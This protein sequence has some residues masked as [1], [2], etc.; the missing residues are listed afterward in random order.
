[1]SDQPTPAPPAAAP[2]SR[3]ALARTGAW[4]LGAALL[5]L[6]VAAVFGVFSVLRN[7]AGTAWLLQNVPGLQVTAPRGALLGQ[8]FGADRLNFSWA[9]GAA[10]VELEG[11]EL[12]G[13]HWRWWLRPGVW[14]G[15]QA[16]SLTARR[17]HIRSGPP[18]ETPLTAPRTLRLPVEA[19]IARVAA[20]E[21]QI[22]ELPPVRA[23]SGRVH[24]G[25]Q[26][27]ALHRIDNLA[28]EWDRLRGS[29]QARLEADAPFALDAA[30]ALQSTAGTPWTAS[31]S[32]LGPL[33]AFE[34]RTTLRGE[35]KAG[36]APPALEAQVQLLP[37]AAWPVGTLNARTQALDLSALSSQAPQTRLSGRAVVTS[38]G[39]AAP[40]GAQIDFDN[41]LPGRWNEGR[42][43]VR[44][45]QLGLLADPARRDRVE[46]DTFDIQF[47]DVSAAAGRWSGSGT[48][49]GSMFTLETRMAALRPQLLDA[50]APAMTLTGPLSLKIDGL[51]SPAGTAQA[52]DVARALQVAFKG[53]LEGSI[54]GAPQPVSL[55]VEGDANTHRVE[56]HKLHA[57]SGAASAEMNASAER[58]PGPRWQV[59]SEGKL[60]DFDP[61]P[62]FPGAQGSAWR[63]GPHRLNAGWKLDL[64]LAES[65]LREPVLQWLQ[66]LQGEGSLQL[67]NSQLAGVPV[68]AQ[69]QLGQDPGAAK[70]QRS[71]AQGEVLLGSNRITIDG[72]G[73]PA[74][75]GET[76]RVRI[77]VSAGALAELAPLAALDPAL[78][79]WAPRGGS[80]EATVSADGRWPLLHTEADASLK[81]V[82]LGELNVARGSAG[83]NLDLGRQQSLSV[84][85]ELNDITL[86]TRRVTV[87]RGEL[88]GTLGSH[89][90]QLDM[91]AP[92]NP[93]GVL[94][95]V[96][97]IKAQAGT[98][99]QLAAEGSWQAAPGGGG[100]WSGTLQ[101]LTAGV[102][103]GKTDKRASNDASW[104]DVDAVRA[105]VDVDARGEVSAANATAGT[106]KLAG[107]G[108]LRWNE[109]R[110]R[111]A[112]Q[113]PDLTLQAE[114]LPI[115]VAP[116]LQRAQTGIQWGGDLRMS[117]A[118]D[119]RAGE[120][121]DADVRL[122][123]HDGDLQVIEN[124]Q[125]QPLGLTDAD[126]SFTAHDGVWLVK[127]LFAGSTLGTI[128]GA[129]TVRTSP[130][131][132]WPEAAAPIDGA[133]QAQVP[134]L[135]VWARWVPPGWRIEGEASTV[136]RVTGRFGAPEY[137]GELRGTGIG[138]RNL[139]QGLEFSDG[140]VLISLKGDRA[141]IERL[142]IRGG[143]G[144]LT[145]QGGATFGTAP[146]AQLKVTA[147][148]FRV[149]GRIDRQLVASGNAT[150]ALQPDRLRLEGRV[151]IDSGLFDLTR[152][153]APSLDD[154]VTVRREQADDKQRAEA[155]T[156]SPI[157]RTAVV[158]IDIGLGDKLFL[159]GR[160]IDTRLAGDLKVST[161][162]GRLAVNGSVRAVD[163]TYNAYGQNLEI[164]R[165]LVVFSGPVADPQLNI[166][167]LRQNLDVRVGVAIAGSATNPRVRLYSDPEMSE[168]DKLSW[169][170]LG[171][172]PDGLGRTDTALVQGAALALLAGEG[173][174]PT[175]KVLK[176][177]GIDDLSF[178]QT[179]G[180]TRDTVIMLGKQLNRQW[181]VGYE[182]GVN[183]ASGS[184]QVIY[185]IAQRFTLRAQSGE[186]N[187]LDLI[188]TWRLGED[189]LGLKSPK[190]TKKPDSPP[191]K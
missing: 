36:Q 169:L 83:W 174:G 96:L 6:P 25:A 33:T 75:S 3:F 186:D 64:A 111:A 164:E 27:G 5:V 43:P 24:A 65:A 63:K 16:D 50:R 1:M 168:T 40:I 84:R 87:L 148:R 150:L 157:A 109:I 8:N 138:V 112:G 95:R 137:T 22:D 135:S 70:A 106:A 79:P 103:D 139:L 118:I 90:L 132:R 128:S 28:F 165:G 155:A 180:D 4:A 134:N 20:D 66:T 78:A 10:G 76:D 51:P 102:W 80:L 129:V 88:S 110:Y 59:R 124:G 101:R 125:V 189:P 167:A 104:V 34:L 188:W 13:A 54:D 94:E 170:I 187:S 2:K 71:R 114:L 130:Q 140:D 74:G 190:N 145:A 173:E 119:I 156:V 73:D 17:V 177:I 21:L 117:A 131:R 171:R 172:G 39:M 100:T 142:S 116:M 175:D 48:W 41:T 35:A 161:P 92:I 52:G 47:G 152:S 162:G 68:Q 91:A 19:Q 67:T 56:L 166:L 153:D 12:R 62:W 146:A 29:G 49:L 183:A 9:A 69:L 136:A 122:R 147:Q 151:G 127:P 14:A 179:E 99:A 38:Q 97:A 115:A 31:A 121:F 46:L 126:L 53:A 158:A 108:A 42:L 85:A 82:R 163:G 185:R 60:V 120:R 77:E 44:R 143:D 159:R 113:Q 181:Y 178:R 57:R 30:L 26:D 144:T 15:L 72:S 107:G 160:G 18:S 23:L 7:E 32:A 105:Q 176:A 182:R 86:G 45:L 93:P 133:L 184:W 98:Q 37:F 81:D 58:T 149:I 89:R 191:P 154:D 61:V 55:T 141:E 11:V 123:R